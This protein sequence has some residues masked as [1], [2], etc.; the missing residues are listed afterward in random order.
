MALYGAL[1]Y[2]RRVKTQNSMYIVFK[3]SF[4]LTQIVLALL[5]RHS[6]RRQVEV[7]TIC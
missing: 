3:S 4:F 7:I 6:L 1:Q 2:V 5:R